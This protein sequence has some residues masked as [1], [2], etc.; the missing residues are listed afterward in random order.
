GRLAGPR[1]A[2]DG[3]QL[4]FRYLERHTAERVDGRLA[5]AVAPRHVLGGYDWAGVGRVGRDG[6]ADCDGVAHV[7]FL[8]GG[9]HRV[10]HQSLT[11]SMQTAPSPKV[12]LT[13]PRTA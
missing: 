6:R 13:A 9:L 4:S 10:F 11:T 12:R 2:H 8:L 1:R 7:K 5:G 3:G